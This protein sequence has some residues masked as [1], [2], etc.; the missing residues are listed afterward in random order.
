MFSAIR[1]SAFS[2]V[3]ALNVLLIFQ[4]RQS[5]P[6]WSCGFNLQPVKLVGRFGVFFLSYT[7]LGFNYGFISTSAC[8]SSPGICSWSCPGELGYAPVRAR[9]GGGAAAW[10]AGVLAAPGTQGGWRLGQQEIECSRRVW[11][12]VLANTVQYS[13]LDSPPVRKTGRPQYTGSQR[14]GHNW[15]DPVCI[16]PKLGFYFSFFLWQLC[17]SEGWVWR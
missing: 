11:Q 8:E 1:T 3:G 14:I 10:V 5:L 13:C 17:P 7:A 15:S 12:P 6:S 4:K 16:D 9:C 2:F